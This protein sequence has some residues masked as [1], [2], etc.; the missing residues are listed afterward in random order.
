MLIELAL[1]VLGATV[2]A[3]VALHI[4]T[5]HRLC[6]ARGTRIAELERQVDSLHAQGLAIHTPDTNHT[7]PQAQI[8]LPQELAEFIAGF[9]DPDDREEYHE[10]VMARLQRGADAAEVARE[11]EL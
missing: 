1:G 2:L 5:L 11:F 7:E 8:E 3:L 10:Y 4:G 6:S 9:E